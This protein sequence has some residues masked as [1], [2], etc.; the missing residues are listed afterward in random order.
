MKSKSQSESPKANQLDVHEQDVHEPEVNKFQIPE[1]YILFFKDYKE[2]NPTHSWKLAFQKFRRTFPD[3]PEFDLEHVKQALDEYR[4]DLSKKI[5]SSYFQNWNSIIQNC[6]PQDISL[7]NSNPNSFFYQHSVPGIE[8]VVGSFS[9]Q[10]ISFFKEIISSLD[11]YPNWGNLSLVFPGRNGH[12]LYDLYR[13]L[14]AKNEIEPV[15]ISQNMSSFNAL[16]YFTPEQDEELSQFILNKF[17]KG[18][19]TTIKMVSE[20]ALKIYY[21]ANPL[22][23]KAAVMNFKKKNNK[24][25]NF[26]MDHSQQNFSNLKVK[27]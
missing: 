21:Q 9:T 11:Q 20:K 2:K 1:Q 5:D 15:K 4:K 19:R 8:H 6:S 12:Q 17:K 18:E 25:I 7:I 26:P 23:H 16:P 14:L 27:Q 24:N 13:S 22:A 3:A 10:E